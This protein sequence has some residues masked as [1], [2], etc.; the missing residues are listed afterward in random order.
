MI[1]KGLCHSKEDNIKK[2]K[3]NEWLNDK[4]QTKICFTFDQNSYAEYE[5]KSYNSM[6]WCIA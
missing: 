6:S 1:N 2:V 3:A 5:K 4:S